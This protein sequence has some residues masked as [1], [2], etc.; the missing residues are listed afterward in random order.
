MRD[1]FAAHTQDITNSVQYVKQQMLHF[2]PKM[3]EAIATVDSLT[4]RFRKTEARVDGFYKQI[5][6]FASQKLD[7]VHFKAE[8]K[9][10]SRLIDD[11]NFKHDEL[12]NSFQQLENFV[13]KY[14]PLRV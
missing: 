4:Q 6:E 5:L 3:V 14:Q 10:T 2:E 8:G 7:V 9:E 1:H 13:E 11:L 12:L